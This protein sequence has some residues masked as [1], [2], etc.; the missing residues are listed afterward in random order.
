MKSIFPAAPL[1][2]AGQLLVFAPR[3]A[4]MGE[5]SV[6]RSR[7]HGGDMLAWSLLGT[8]LLT[9][10]LVT[11]CGWCILRHQRKPSPEREFLDHWCRKKSGTGGRLVPGPI[12]SVSPEPITPT[13]ASPGEPWEK[14][15]DWW[16]KD[17]SPD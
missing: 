12:D 16:R 5:T 9:L 17:F 2:I 1:V 13:A 7:S 10:A 15:A 4:A 8:L 14:H 6:T 3:A 11:F